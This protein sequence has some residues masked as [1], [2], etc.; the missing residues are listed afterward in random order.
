MSK[1]AAVVVHHRSYDTISAAVSALL[2]QGIQP[3]NLVLIDNSEQ[4]ERRDE[5]VAA[6]PSGIATV[7]ESN[8][9]YGAAVNAGIDFF[10]SRQQLPPEV[11]LV[12]THETQPGSG[13]VKELLSAL[14]NDS[15]AAAG[16]PTLNSGPDSK[17]IWSFGG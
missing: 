1:V 7:F 4:P 5:L 14:R 6:L 2:D 11:L 12:S 3:H 9:G 16:G 17:L 8:R 13:A 15:D 10:E